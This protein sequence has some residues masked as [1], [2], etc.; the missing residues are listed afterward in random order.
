MMCVVVVVDEWLFLCE[1]D[2]EGVKI[3]ILMAI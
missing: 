2:G 1:V 3:L